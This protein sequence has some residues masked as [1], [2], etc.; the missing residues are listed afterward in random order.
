MEE[1]DHVY[2]ALGEILVVLMFTDVRECCR[3]IL[4]ALT[5]LSYHWGGHWFLESRGMDA[6]AREGEYGSLT[7][8]TRGCH[9]K[10]AVNLYFT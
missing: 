6:V 8:G 1:I 10:K 9:G 4:E 7:M 3:E 2:E 5:V